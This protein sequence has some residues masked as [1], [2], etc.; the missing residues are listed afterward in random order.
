MQ[1]HF[2]SFESSELQKN[3]PES[4]SHCSSVEDRL[5]TYGSEALGTIEQLG[6]I[7]GS[8]EK[9][10]ALVEHFGSIDLLSRASVEQLQTFVPRAKA[11]RLISSL[12]LGAVV[13]REERQRRTLED[14]LAVAELCS[15][16]RFLSHESLRVVLLNTKQQLIKIATVSQG[17]VNESI[18]HPREIFKPVIVHSAY[19]FVMVHNHPSGDPSPS[20]ADLR[21]TRRIN[22]ASRILQINLLDHVIIGAPAPKRN[23]YFSFKE[24]GV[25]G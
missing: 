21:L 1:Q 10:Q 20:D 6:L 15:E 13:L 24:A 19:S 4:S 14:P 8:Q 17:S 9:A 12:R 16:M 11:L 23:S 25:I 2:F 22:E 18:A 5:A 3:K 7:V